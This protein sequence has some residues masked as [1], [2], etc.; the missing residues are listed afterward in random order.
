MP[1]PPAPPAPPASTPSA[2]PAPP[3]PT[4]SAPPAPPAPTPSA[5]PASRFKV[6]LSPAPSVPLNNIYFLK[7][8]IDDISNDICYRGVHCFYEDCIKSVHFPVHKCNHKDNCDRNMRDKS[9]GFIHDQHESVMNRLE[10]NKFELYKG[11]EKYQPIWAKTV[12]GR[13]AHFKRDI[14]KS[15]K[16]NHNVCINWIMT[17]CDD[18]YC[19]RNHYIPPSYK[20]HQCENYKSSNCKF[21]SKYCNDIHGQTD[22]ILWHIGYQSQNRSRSR[23]RSRGKY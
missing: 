21:A 19:D 9:C 11:W 17:K 23:S 16:L 14:I 12:E 8:E 1:P 7:R 13:A 5:P 22:L 10:N 20:V 4:T 2:P 3:A 18:L 6:I 15:I